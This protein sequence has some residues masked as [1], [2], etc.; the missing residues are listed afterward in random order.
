VNPSIASSAC[1]DARSAANSRSLASTTRSPRF[2]QARGSAAAPRS[3]RWR[4]QYV[5]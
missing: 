4:D 3:G 1:S 2:L 5:A